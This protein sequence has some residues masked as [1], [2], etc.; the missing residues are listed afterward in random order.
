[1]PNVIQVKNPADDSLSFYAGPGKKPV[2]DLQD[3]RVAVYDEPA[4]AA[5]DEA[6]FA[7]LDPVRAPGVHAVFVEITVD[8]DGTRTV[9]A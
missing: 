3:A 7:K 6:M 1:M 5:D 8:A 9:V 4:V 2:S